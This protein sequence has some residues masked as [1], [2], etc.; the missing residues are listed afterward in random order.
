MGGVFLNF[1]QSA[2]AYKWLCS[3]IFRDTSPKWQVLPRILCPLLHFTA[4]VVAG[5]NDSSSAAPPVSKPHTSSEGIIASHQAL[6]LSQ[7]ASASWLRKLGLKGEC[8]GRPGSWVCLPL[9]GCLPGVN[10]PRIVSLEACVA[11]RGFNV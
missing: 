11:Q 10:T 6:E 9:G 3:P 7:P 8:W 1:L 4:P 5:W 2:L